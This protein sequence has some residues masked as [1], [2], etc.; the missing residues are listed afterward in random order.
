MRQGI[1]CKHFP[2]QI[3]NYFKDICHL[4]SRLARMHEWEEVSPV[5]PQ[6]L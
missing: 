2:L 3:Q 6:M 4:F 5:K 1:L